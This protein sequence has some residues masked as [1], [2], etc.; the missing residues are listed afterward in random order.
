M[1]KPR[2]PANPEPGFYKLRLVRK[3]PF[4]AARIV[5]DDATGWSV[6]IDGVSFGPHPNPWAI[7]RMHQVW[8]Y[9]AAI[10]EAEHDF[11]IAYAEWA[12]KHSP[13][14]PVVHPTKQINIFDLPAPF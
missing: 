12:R 1:N 3:G 7:A 13:D 6:L 2:D 8:P 11:M 5:H 9:A 10:T 14:D 4:V